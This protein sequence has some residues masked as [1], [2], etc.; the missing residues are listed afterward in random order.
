M[1]PLFLTPLESCEDSVEI[2][3]HS[4]LEGNMFVSHF[5]S[6]DLPEVDKRFLLQQHHEPPGTRHLALA[7]IIVQGYLFI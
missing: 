5:L 1:K 6:I 4:K 3:L 2:T 7:I